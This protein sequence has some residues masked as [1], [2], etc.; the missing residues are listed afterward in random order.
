M[1]IDLM[2]KKVKNTLLCFMT[3]LYTCALWR[4]C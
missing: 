4:S 3:S 1:S 2:E